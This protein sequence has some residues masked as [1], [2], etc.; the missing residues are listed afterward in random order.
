MVPPNRMSTGRAARS[1]AAATR[2]SVC[3][4]ANRSPA[5]MNTTNS[6]RASPRPWFI[7]SYTPRS[8]P[9]WSVAIRP[10]CARIASSV[11]SV[12]PPSTTIHSKSGSVCPRML[13]AVAVNPDRS[14]RTT[15]ITLTR[16][17]MPN[18]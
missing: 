8:G 9:L 2:A 14:F 5:F 13:P 15:V 17:V 3:G 6:P 18:L 11:P 7:A 4:S 12:E 10:A 1:I 16:N